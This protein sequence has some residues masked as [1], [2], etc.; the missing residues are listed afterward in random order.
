MAQNPYPGQ[1]YPQQPQQQ[2]TQPGYPPQGA[3]PPQSPPAQPAPSVPSGPKTPSVLAPP[4]GPAKMLYVGLVLMLV[5]FGAKQIL[6]NLSLNSSASL[7]ER[8][9][10]EAEMA[11]EIG[12]IDAALDPID[13]EIEELEAQ[14]PKPPKPSSGDGAKDE[15]KPDDGKDFEAFMEKK[16]KHEEKVAKLRLKRAEQD[17]DL[18]DKR[19]EVRKKYGPELREAS[20]AMVGARASG[21]GNAQLTL[22][23][24]LVLD[25][26]KIAGAG[27]CILAGLGIAADKEQPIGTQIYAA[28]IGGI[29]FLAVVAGGLS[30]LLS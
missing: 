4:S 25:F 15:A 10:L 18:D 3:Q 6:V 21:L 12:E 30:A 28:V 2:L 27:L 13:T 1:G 23:A 5:A 7:F 19:R 24:K 11:V 29:S 17:A 22:L 8:E 16:N 20:R 14:A 26:L 9:K